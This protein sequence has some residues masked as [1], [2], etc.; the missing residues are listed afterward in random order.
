MLNSYDP[1]PQP[2]QKMAYSDDV[3]LEEP[4]KIL[5][6]MHNLSLVRPEI[7]WSGQDIA[8]NSSLAEASI[9]QILGDLEKAGYVKS[10]SDPNGV[11]KFYLTSRGI[12]KI[13]TL[14][15]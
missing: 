10:Y 12:I 1:D 5:L 3:D 15:T 2:R 14:F 4:E 8:R 11:R 13:S 6:A 9:Q 7:A